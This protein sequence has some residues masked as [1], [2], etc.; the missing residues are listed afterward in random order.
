[1]KKYLKLFD[2]NLIEFSIIENLAD[3]V[4]QIT[5]I[6]EAKKDLIPLGMEIS[7]KGL[8]SW[9]KNR[10]IPKNRAYVNSF[11]A[12]CGLNANRPMDVISVCKGLS[13]N[14]S[15]WVV[16]ENFSGT[17]E[18][19]NLFDNNFSRVLATIAF[20]GYGSSTRSSLSSSPEFTTNGMLPKCW[21]RID[22]K[23]FLYKGATS[24]ASNTGNEPF[25]ELYAYEIGTAM[26]M[27]VVPYR[28]SKWKKH[29]CSAC[30][31]FTSKELA[32]VPAGHIVKTGG[33]KAVREY[34]KKLGSEYVDALNDMIVLDAVIYNTDRHFGNFGVL[35]D[36][37]TNKIVAP[38][39]L[40]DHGNSLFNMAGEENWADEKLLSEY[41]R[42]LLPSV[43]EDYVEEAKAVLDKRL[44]EKLRKLL[45]YELKKSG[46]YNYSSDRL[47]MISKM[48]QERAQMIL[49]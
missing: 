3:P 40:F 27:N 16:E 48:V 2:T 20:T 39:P 5:W 28:I 26:G 1:M 30:E 23:I 18:D 19:N 38:A 33:M 37:K 8:T 32:F 35:V 43:Y 13:L 6:N 22:G 9:L 45:I 21:R 4:L 14:D 41:A 36:S 34:Y 17:F 31:L 7:D 12:K 49:D 42:T 10:T 15:Y 24:G 29:L 47:K 44:K 46:V 25:S 11:L